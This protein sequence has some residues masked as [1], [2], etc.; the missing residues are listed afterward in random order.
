MEQWR[1]LPRVVPEPPLWKIHWREM[2][3]SAFAPWIARMKSIPQNP[4]WHGEGDVWMH[5]EMVC[6]E[7]A[8]FPQWRAL[9]KRKREELFVAALLHD[10]GKIPCTRMEDGA[11]VSPNHSVV[12]SRM[13][14]EILWLEYGVCGEPSL[15]RFRETVCSLIRYHSVPL[16]MLEQEDPSRC[17]AKM[18]SMGKLTGDFSLRLLSIL[19]LADVKGRT[20]IDREEA[21][22]A[23]ELFRLQAEE[24]GCLD[25]PQHIFPDPCSEYA[26]LS[27]KNIFPGQK[28]FDESWGEVILLSAL[29]GTGKDTWIK[30]HGSGLAE[31]SLDSLRRQMNISPRENQGKVVSAAWEQA[32]SYLRK[33]IPFVWNATDLTPAICGK[34]VRLFTDYHASVRIVY[35]ETGWEEQMRRNAGRKAIV[36]E[37]EI[38]RMLRKMSPPESFEAHKV[39]WLC[40]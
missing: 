19:A 29:P 18:A 11:W 17:A 16:H 30:S 23:V 37:T 8:A 7:L 9:D 36:P 33:K 6:E 1:N 21:L 10:I 13:A 40:V 38:R 14:R 35:L 32:R 28:L 34:Q 3:E 24:S 2:E 39:Q 20:C 15:M 22:E 25:G 31:I 26:Y 4:I 12:G 5:T 27:G